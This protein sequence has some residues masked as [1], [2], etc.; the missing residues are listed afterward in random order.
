M[1]PQLTPTH[2]FS[3][4]WPSLAIAAG[5]QASSPAAAKARA[6]AISKA[7][8]DESPAPR[9][10]SPD[11]HALPTRQTIAGLLQAP[12]RPLEVFDPRRLAAA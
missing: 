11:E 4:R 5:S 1:M 3:A 6:V 9:G 8:D 10:T 12:G 2:W 7:A